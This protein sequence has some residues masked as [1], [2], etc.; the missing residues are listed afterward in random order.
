MNI[1]QK[2]NGNLI[3]TDEIQE[4]GPLTLKKLN[5]AIDAI[6][7]SGKS[8]MLLGTVTGRTAE[9]ITRSFIAVA[10]KFGSRGFKKHIRRRKSLA[11][12]GDEL[13][14]DW[15]NSGNIKWIK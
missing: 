15:L 10:R 3:V 1:E 13:S 7:E 11:R 8:M 5:K 6:N 9:Q 14:V 12:N 2:E 4:I